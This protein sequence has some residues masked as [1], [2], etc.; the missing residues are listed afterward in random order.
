MRDEVE[1]RGDEGESSTASGNWSALDDAGIVPT[2]SDIAMAVFTAWVTDD[3][4]AELNGWENRRYD[5]RLQNRGGVHY[6]PARHHLLRWRLPA[7][8]FERLQ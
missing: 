1:E 4:I 3:L 2:E 6:A 5:A 8:R 7:L